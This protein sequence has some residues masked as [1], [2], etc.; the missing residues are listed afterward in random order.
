[1]GNCGY[2][3]HIRVLEGPESGEFMIQV[4]LLIKKLGLM[5]RGPD[6]SIFDLKC[7]LMSER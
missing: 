6:I 1:M 4:G 3:P 7:D 5:G 2:S